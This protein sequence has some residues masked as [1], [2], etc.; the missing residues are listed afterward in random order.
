M[1]YDAMAHDVGTHRHVSVQHPDRDGN[2]TEGSREVVETD[3][4][5]QPSAAGHR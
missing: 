5:G 1:S 4:A 3:T 2:E